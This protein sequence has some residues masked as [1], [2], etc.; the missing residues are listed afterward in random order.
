LAPSA[1]RRRLAE[2]VSREAFRRL[3][4]AKTPRIE[5]LIEG[6]G[7]SRRRVTRALDQLVHHG[8]AVVEDDMVVGMR[9]LTVRPSRHRMAL[10]DHQFYTWCAYDLIGVTAALEVDAVVGTTC[11]H[12]EE[13]IEVHIRQGQPVDDEK[14]VGWLPCRTP[15]R[16][17]EEFCPYANLFCEEEHLLAWRSASEGAEGEIADLSALA[18]HGREDWGDIA[19][20]RPVTL[21]G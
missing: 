12:C 9:G 14:I 16:V 1:R 5:E 11:G 6:T 17:I 4:D 3:L 10:G 8:Y 2:A 19:G 20:Q 21:R 13:P 7:A 15:G 18:E